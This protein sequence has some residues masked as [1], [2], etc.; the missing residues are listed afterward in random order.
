MVAFD[1]KVRSRFF[2][3]EIPDQFS[4]SVVCCSVGVCRRDRRLVLRKYRMVI[5][6][7]GFI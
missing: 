2:E 5:C 6:M 4:R 7:M 1:S 3:K